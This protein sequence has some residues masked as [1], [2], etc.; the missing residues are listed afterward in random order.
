MN[1]VIIFGNDTCAAERLAKEINDT[2]LAKAEVLAYEE[3]CS[4]KDGTAGIVAVIDGGK[5]LGALADVLKYSDCICVAAGVELRNAFDLVST[6]RQTA[7]GAQLIIPPD[8]RID[9]SEVLKKL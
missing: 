4:H 9:C 6:L 1:T 8:G 3:I 7:P 2:A 5:E